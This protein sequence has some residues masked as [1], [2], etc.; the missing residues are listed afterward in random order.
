MSDD[1]TIR[2][3]E[4]TD[5]HKDYLQLINTF[6]RNPEMKSYEEFCF[7][8]DKINNQQSFIF[9]IEHDNKIV[10]TIKCLVEQKLHNNFKCVLHIEDLVTHKDY[11]KQGLATKLLQYAFNLAKECNCYKI[12]LCSNPEN[13]NFYLHKGFIQKGVEFT[14]YI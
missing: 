3:I 11:M 1:Y 13:C 14:K 7:I 8:L 12:V 6:T 2:S 5:Y 10:S 9:V 4:Y